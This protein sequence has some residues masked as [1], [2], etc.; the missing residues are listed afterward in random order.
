MSIAYLQS[1][2]KHKH[3][4]KKRIS[5]LNELT[6]FLQFHMYYSFQL[7]T[8]M[9]FKMPPLRRQPLQH[10]QLSQKLVYH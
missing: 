8:M 1:I 7:D 10:L 4:K 3:V 5:A 9:Y 6:G 2:K